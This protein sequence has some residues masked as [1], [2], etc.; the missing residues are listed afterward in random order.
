MTPVPKTR[1]RRLRSRA[2]LIAAT[3]VL[4][5][6]VIGL[7]WFFSLRMARED[8]SERARDRE[9]DELA[10]AA[11]RFVQTLS[12]RIPGKITYG[13]PN[14]ESAQT[15]V[16][17]SRAP[18]GSVIVLLDA[19]GHII[20]HPSLRESPNLR[21][22]DYSD[23]LVNLWPN[24]EQIALGG[25]KPGTVMTGESDL[26]AGPVAMAVKYSGE[27]GVRVVVHQSAAG[28]AAVEAQ[29]TSGFTMWGGV[30]GLGVLVVSLGGSI[31]LV[32]RYD[33]LLAKANEEL[34]AEV[35]RRTR[36]GL[37]IRNGLIFGLAKLADYRDTDT[38]KHL[39]RICTYCE[40]LANEMLGRHAEID[41]P[42]IERL[43]LAASMHDIGKVGIP[44]SILLKP[45]ALTPAER[46]LMEL[47]PM[48]GADT[49]VAIRHR[50]GDDELLNMGIQVT[51]S[52]HERH[53][54]AGYPYGLSGDQI[55]IAARIVGLA[56]MYDA[57]TSKRVYKE[58]MS[59]EEAVRTICEGRGTHFDPDVVDAFML[60]HQRFEAAGSVIRQPDEDRPPL[61]RAVEKAEAARAAA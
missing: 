7:G 8:V 26:L 30:A 43:K 60:V 3:V 19:T 25:I 24:N 37:A 20:C 17:Q 32:R 22:L 31:L 46:R 38:G 14:W 57:L 13:S 59:H 12:E 16:E 41:R 2:S 36:R 18:R 34:E 51:L 55:P 4:Q 42:W 44:D 58:A 33:S 29:M 39:E 50:V 27:S 48:I 23:V 56:D 49:L 52:H 47:H 28:M 6:A 45:G 10:Q 40:L 21:K 54:G 1:L 61:L 53:D 9:M 5:A 11:D 35:E 15:L